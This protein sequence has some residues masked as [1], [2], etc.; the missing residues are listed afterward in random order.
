MGVAFFGRV[1]TGRVGAKEIEFSDSIRL[2]SGEKNAPSAYGWQFHQPDGQTSSILVNL[3]P[4]PITL[5][6]EMLGENGTMVETFSSAPDTYIESNS[7]VTARQVKLG[8]KLVLPP[9]SVTLVNPT[10]NN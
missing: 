3:G 10:P 5:N 4:V 7:S 9:L 8:P 6:S 1:A 2:Q